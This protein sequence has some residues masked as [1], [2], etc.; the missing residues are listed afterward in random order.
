MFPNEQRTGG[1]GGSLHRVPLATGMNKALQNHWGFVL[2]P[3]AHKLRLRTQRQNCFH[4]YSSAVSQACRSRQPSS[5]SRV[6]SGYSEHV[7][8]G[9]KVMVCGVQEPEL[10][11]PSSSHLRSPNGL[12]SFPVLSPTLG[13][14][15]EGCLPR[16][17]GSRHD[18]HLLCVHRPKGTSVP[19]DTTLLDLELFGE[20]KNQTKHNVF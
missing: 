17:Q 15:A 10:A 3:S 1:L 2:W 13:T 16:T 8:G 4:A 14:G 5:A 19:W 7:K 9:D 11:D 6:T 20:K 18:L 12:A